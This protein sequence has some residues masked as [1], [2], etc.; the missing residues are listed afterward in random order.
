MLFSLLLHVLHINLSSFH[1]NLK[2]NPRY[3]SHKVNRRVDDL[4]EVLF[5]IEEDMFLTR[6]R[7]EFFITT[8]EISIDREGNR[9]NRGSEISDDQV[10]VLILC[11]FLITEILLH[12]IR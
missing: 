7:K 12:A 9:H 5:K 3:L 6:K 10:Q 8:E 11:I 4:I 2:T 1:S